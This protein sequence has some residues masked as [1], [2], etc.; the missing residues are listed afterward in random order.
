M[1]SDTINVADKVPSNS[2]AQFSAN[3]QLVTG[4]LSD[5]WALIT[6]LLSL[7]MIDEVT[8]I[9]DM[10]FINDSKYTVAQLKQEIIAILGKLGII[11]N[12]QP[13]APKLALS[14]DLP[15]VAAMKSAG[16]VTSDKV[17]HHLQA[18]GVNVA[19]LSP[20]ELWAYVQIGINAGLTFL[21]KLLDSRK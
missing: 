12:G 14:G 10:L 4:A 2:M 19:K 15:E 18:K 16:P 5:I 7:N 17:L 6:K 21:Q 13:V 3:N 8:K 11:A 9:I 1:S 20:A